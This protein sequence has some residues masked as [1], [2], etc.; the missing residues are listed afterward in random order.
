[1]TMPNFAAITNEYAPAIDF[2]KYP[3]DPVSAGRF[4]S[5][6]M[7]AADGCEYIARICKEFSELEQVLLRGKERYDADI[8]SGKAVSNPS[9]AALL[10]LISNYGVSNVVRHQLSAV[11]NY[12]LIRY[13]SGECPWPNDHWD[14]VCP[15]LA[16]LAKHLRELRDAPVEIAIEAPRA[17][18]H[19]EP[20][21]GARK[22]TEALKINYHYRL[23]VVNGELTGTITLSINGE[24]AI[25]D[26]ECPKDDVKVRYHWVTMP[27]KGYDTTV[28]SLVRWFDGVAAAAIMVTV[29]PDG[30]RPQ[31]VTA[32]LEA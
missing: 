19:A 24:L 27:K 12:E 32:T 21:Q 2:N 9:R 30:G 16:D 3:L 25:V 20:N 4:I 17:A 29:Y 7:R 26:V 5:F 14:V 18:Y 10:D 22:M 11:D 31:T 28:H 6:D 8:H 1:M 15:E 13:I 23:N